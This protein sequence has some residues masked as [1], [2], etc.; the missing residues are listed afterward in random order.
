[1]S[2][3]E[4]SARLRIPARLRPRGPFTLHLRAGCYPVVGLEDALQFSI[5]P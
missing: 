1:M 3:L 4:R 2:M 5:V